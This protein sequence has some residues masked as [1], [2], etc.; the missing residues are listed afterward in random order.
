MNN[1]VFPLSLREIKRT[2][3]QG[4]RRFAAGFLAVLGLLLSA[5]GAFSPVHGKTNEE[6]ASPAFVEYDL[7]GKIF[8][9]PERYLGG[10]QA[11][12]RP[13]AV[14]RASF[15]DVAFWL[16]DGSPSSVRGISL[17]TYW[18]KDAGRPNSGDDDFVVSAFHVEYLPPDLAQRVVLP[19]ARLRNSVTSLLAGP[20]R[21]QEFVYGLTC[22]NST[23]PNIHS[24]DCAPPL[25]SDL[26][27]ILHSGWDR[28]H[29]PGGRP[30]N[31]AWQLDLYS[32]ADGLWIWVRFPEVALRR[33]LDVVCRTL[34]LVRSWQVP[35]E[36]A[37]A[38][39]PG[40]RTAHAIK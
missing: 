16:S 10:W 25:P 28:R 24:V 38:G 30:P 9:V 39:C 31:P 18:P 22:Y 12:K 19:A 27:V 14:I 36:Q 7:R 8:R 15:F 20:E 17:N 33:W 26:E 40:P 32:K 35:P 6:M 3:V 2:F 11:T 34:T 5:T 29:W 37:R 21:R 13:Q 1:S 4:D 23:Q